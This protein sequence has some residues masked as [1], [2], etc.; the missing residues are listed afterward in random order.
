M[1]LKKTKNTHTPSRFCNE[2]YLRLTYSARVAARAAAA[3]QHSSGG[4]QKEERKRAETAPLPLREIAV[5]LIPTAV[6]A[7]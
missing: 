2:T 3:K 4:S 6:G 7:S 5:F 1:R